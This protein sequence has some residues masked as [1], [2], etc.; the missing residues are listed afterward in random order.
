M[1]NST[2]L[3]SNKPSPSP[4]DSNHDPQ[5][6]VSSQLE[7]IVNTLHDV[8]SQLAEMNNKVKTIDHRV[9]TVELHQQQMIGTSSTPPSEVTSS[10]PI[11]PMS[12]TELNIALPMNKNSGIINKTTDAELEATSSVSSLDSRDNSLSPRKKK[13]QQ[14]ATASSSEDLDSSSSS[15]ESS[16]Y[17]TSRITSKNKNKNSKKKTQKK[18]DHFQHSIIGSL[19]ANSSRVPRSVVL[20]QQ[21]PSQEHIMLNHLSL[22]KVS[23]FLKLL[24]DYETTYGINIV[25]QARIRQEVKERLYA[26]YPNKLDARTFNKLSRTKVIRFLYKYIAPTDV[27]KFAAEILRQILRYP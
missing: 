16:G 9:L 5:Q 20:Y 25:I 13:T 26:K 8:V 24:E 1:S 23:Q 15:N 12:P 6:F 18:G 21:V 27:S 10:A 17:D 3:P 19:A 22:E 7:L 11:H 2:S 4:A 14:N